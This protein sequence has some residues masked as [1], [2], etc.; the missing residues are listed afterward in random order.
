M[1]KLI[2]GHKFEKDL[3][4]AKRRGNN[5]EKLAAIV[6]SLLKE[7]ALPPRILNHKLKGEFKDCWECHVEPNWLL[8]YQRTAVSIILLRTGTHADLF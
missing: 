6:T 2:Y 5:V 8:I 7:E 1:L 4:L 3:K